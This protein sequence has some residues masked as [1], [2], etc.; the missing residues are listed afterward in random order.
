MK[1][2][3]AVVLAFAMVFSFAACG[4]KKGGHGDDELYI[5][6]IGAATGP[7]AVYGLAVKYGA[8]IAV[9][10]INAAGGINGMK[11][12]FDFQDSQGDPESAKSAYGKLIDWGMDVSIGTV[13][14]GEMASVAAESK[15]DDMFMISPSASNDTCIEES[16]NAFRICFYD[17]FQGTAAADYVKATLDGKKVAVFYQSDNDYSIGLYEAF[18]K[19][20]A[21]NGT[22]IVLEQSFTED[23]TDYS[24]Q[25]NTLADSKAEVI[26][27]PF[28]A[29]AAATFLSQAKNG[30]ENA[31]FAEGTYFFGC[32]GLDGILEEVET[33]STANNVVMLTPFAA[34]STDPD[35]VNFV[36]AYKAKR[37]GAIP[38][39]F[40]ADGYDAVYAIKAV[41]EAMNVTKSSEI[42]GAKVAEAMTSL[43]FSGVTGDMTWT[44]DGNTQK[45]ATAVIYN[46]G[47][48][49]EFGK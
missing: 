3:L 27:I 16:S 44:A 18:K 9:E 6:G 26:F 47:V 43:S 35:V 7:Y 22:E 4:G 48:D 14:S 34:S 31:V 29:P 12:V 33:P 20:A 19:Q 21:V 1:K 5:G 28:Y 32:D 2:F 24:T 25:I 36:N 30:T 40:A 13:M 38:N 46:D 49:T 11:V 15:D 39:Q 8:E 42:S 23:E 45:L 37:D 17:S 41:L 10:E